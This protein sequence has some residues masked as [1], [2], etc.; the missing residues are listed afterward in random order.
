MPG[1]YWIPAELFN[2]CWEPLCSPVT[3]PKE[4]GEV[5]NQVLIERE[6]WQRVL[7]A[8]AQGSVSYGLVKC[9]PQPLPHPSPFKSSGL[10]H[11]N[12]FFFFFSLQTDAFKS[13]EQDVSNLNGTCSSFPP[14]GCDGHSGSDAQSA[15]SRCLS[16]GFTS[17]RRDSRP[18]VSKGGCKKE[19]G[20]A[21]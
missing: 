21:L 12:S 15:A 2:P 1:C 13:L 9:Q 3:F 16:L 17:W 5:F 14:M 7:C 8:G 20:Q 18:L 10:W 19:R 11:L 4:L 6:P